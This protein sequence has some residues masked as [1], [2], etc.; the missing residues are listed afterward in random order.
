[1]I[2]CLVLAILVWNFYIGYRRGLFIQGYYTLSVLFAMVV[3]TYTFRG[4]ATALTLWIPYANPARDASVAF[5]TDQNIFS[6]DRVYYAGVAFF[7]V[8]VVVY[9][10]F[11]FFGVFLHFFTID[12][13]D[14]PRFQVIGGVLASVVCLVPLTMLGNILATIPMEGIQNTLSSS[15]VARFLI[16]SYFPIS[17]ILQGLWVSMI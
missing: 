10:I 6:L 1:M 5:F 2:G 12:R 7:L 17:Q 14:Y 16:N 11:H 3:A 4:L 15:W 9:Y 13:L 8:Y